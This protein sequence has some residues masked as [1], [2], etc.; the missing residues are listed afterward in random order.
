MAHKIGN[1]RHSIQH[2]FA[3]WSYPVGLLVG[4]EG[5]EKLQCQAGRFGDV[6][7]PIKV[8]HCCC[9][10]LP[11]SNS[12]IWRL[13]L[14]TGKV[15]PEKGRHGPP[16]IYNCTY[17]WYLFKLNQSRCSCIGTL[18]TKKRPSVYRKKCPPRTHDSSPSCL[19]EPIF[20]GILPMHR[21]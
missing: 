5:S 13:R 4:R 7:L 20:N 9:L 6:S 10:C 3:C 17:L 19:G 11:W 1:N 8:N 14:S 18:A 12:Q 2:S 16:S 21:H 15:E